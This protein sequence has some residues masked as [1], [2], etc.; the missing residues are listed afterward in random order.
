M[1]FIAESSFSE[2]AN[3]LLIPCTSYSH[4]R[5]FAQVGRPLVEKGHN[6]YGIINGDCKKAIGELETAKIEAFKYYTT[7]RRCRVEEEPTEEE[8][9]QMMEMILKPQGPL[10]MASV[11]YMQSTVIGR[12]ADGLFSDAVFDQLR[13]LKID[14]AIVDGMPLAL[15]GY[16]VPYKL[17]VPYVTLTTAYHP[18]IAGVPDLPSFSPV[19]ASSV[20]PPMSFL[21]RVE[22]TILYFASA[23]MLKLLP[24]SRDSLVQ[25]YAGEKEPVSI[26]TLL[27]Q[28]KLWLVNTDIA[29]DYPRASL[30]HIV[31]IGGLSTKPAKPLPENIA[32]IASSAK[33]GL[34]VVSFGSVLKTLPQVLL[35]QLLAAFRDIKDVTIVWKYNGP[36]LGETLP[37]NIH[38]LPWLP[39]NDLLGHP[40]IRLF[41]THS[42]NNGQFEALY[43]GV[44]MIG[45]PVF[46]DQPYNAIRMQAKGF[47]IK[48]SL[49]GLDSTELV[50][51]IR[52]VLDN[53]S[54]S[55]NIKL[56]SKIYKSRPLNA[57]ERAVYWIEHVLSFGTEHLHSPGIHLP[58]Y[59]YWVLDV[60]CFLFSVISVISVVFICMIRSCLRACCGKK[61]KQKLN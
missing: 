5:Y 48:M 14:L 36:D 27:R 47:G 21:E 45:I 20:S 8:K 18:G 50:K 40:N 12:N 61:Q 43:H 30:P 46:G 31:P 54:F 25:E 3:I 17:G 38:V 1:I 16:I 4:V 51:N 34:I 23:Q 6:V 24:G 53:R 37:S 22:N 7:E 58:W 13:S 52:T 2:A 10:S 33:N 49:S 44:P 41:V 32:K 26:S 19:M 28:S 15:Y 29:L 55:D 9:K 60:L 42:G 59:Q 56:A 39:Q 57:R 11:L 35:D